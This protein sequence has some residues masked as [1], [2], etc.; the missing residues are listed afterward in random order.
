MLVEPVDL[1]H[2]PI[3]LVGQVVARL[4]PTLGELDDLLDVEAGL[5]IRVHREADGFEP[6]EGGGL[7]VHAAGLLP[8][9]LEKLV[10]PGRQAP[11]GRH[12]RVDLTKGARATVARIG[13]Q[14]QAGLAALGVDPGELGLRHEDLAARVERRRLLELGRDDRDRPQVGRDVLAGRAVAPG[15]T[16]DEAALLVVE[17]DREAV[18]LELCD[19]AE[20]RRGFGGRRQAEATAHPRVEGPQLVVTEGV[21]QRQHRPAVGDFREPSRCPHRADPLGR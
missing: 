17:A 10:E 1:D 15:R 6:I 9:P 14:R 16:L 13:V 11:A 2:D 12:G 20:V 3:G 5:A 19:V 21:A 4:P 7:A 8:F 18:D